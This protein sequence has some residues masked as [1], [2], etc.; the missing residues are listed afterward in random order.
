MDSPTFVSGGEPA[1]H[2]NQFSNLG[3]YFGRSGWWEEGAQALSSFFDHDLPR[4]DRFDQR[5]DDLL[6]RLEPLKVVEEPQV[7]KKDGTRIGPSNSTATNALQHEQ[8]L[9]PEEYN[10]QGD[11]P[12]TD[13]EPRV[14]G[15]RKD[16]ASGDQ[17]EAA[18]DLKSRREGSE[19][20]QFETRI[21]AQIDQSSGDKVS[22]TVASGNTL[23]TSPDPFVITQ[24]RE[25][26]A[27]VFNAVP[28]SLS[29]S[30]QDRD[31]EN[32]AVLAGTSGDREVT[33]PSSPL[34]GTT[35][36]STRQTS[37]NPSTR[38]TSVVLDRAS[39]FGPSSQKQPVVQIVL[40]ETSD[41]GSLINHT[42]GHRATSPVIVDDS[43]ESEIDSTA[44]ISIV[45]DIPSNDLDDN[46]KDSAINSEAD[47]TGI[48]AIKD[49]LSDQH[50]LASIHDIPSHQP[51][52]EPGESSTSLETD[53]TGLQAIKDELSDQYGLI[54]NPDSS[55]ISLEDDVTVLH[56]PSSAAASFFP[57]N[58][59]SP[60]LNDHSLEAIETKDRLIYE[61][62]MDVADEPLQITLDVHNF[63]AEPT[64]LDS[65][66]N[67]QQL[68]SR[69]FLTEAQII[70]IL[71]DTP[72]PPL[73]SP[74]TPP[75]GFSNGSRVDQDTIGGA[76]PEEHES[77]RTI[78]VPSILELPLIELAAITHK[79]KHGGKSG[80]T[81]LKAV[82]GTYTELSEELTQ[83]PEN[84][85]PAITTA[86]DKGKRRQEESHEDEP[87][88][89][90]RLSLI[91]EA[92]DPTSE[93]AHD[94]GANTGKDESKIP[95]QKGRSKV[96]TRPTNRDSPD[97]LASASPDELAHPPTSNPFA[98][99]KGP[100]LLAKPKVNRSTPRRSHAKKPAKDP[101]ANSTT[102]AAPS[103][104]REGR[105]HKELAGLLE[106]SPPRKAAE[107]AK[108]DV[109]GRLRSHQTDTPGPASI[110]TST[111]APRAELTALPAYAPQP[112][113]ITQ[114]AGVPE[115]Q[116]TPTTTTEA[117]PPKRQ[118]L[119]G[120]NPLGAQ[121]LS[122]LGTIIE[123]RTRTRNATAE[124][125][126]EPITKAT[127]KRVRKPAQKPAAVNSP[128][129]LTPK[130]KGTPAA[131][132]KKAPAKR[133]APE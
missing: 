36:A 21:P 3:D 53:P 112:E 91:P 4:A 28:K 126:N 42:A 128:F 17:P 107:K 5:P 95:I 94:L 58:S 47:P 72:S 69:G 96:T 2:D 73:F 27:S 19:T 130:S 86:V 11:K 118:R 77:S 110:L 22:Q 132:R 71:A 114:T 51:S 106:S 6:E 117:P 14:H 125:A 50:G 90:R 55:I 62:P 75:L 76:E 109:G 121:E 97:E 108:A 103:N 111:P 33:I 84:N 1:S 31:I 113:S 83:H 40:S 98:L 78:T 10:E 122:N 119:A 18:I 88:K 29:L 123:T 13:L 89:K 131:G 115:E 127:P 61:S 52:D 80:G 46:S 30:T 9:R 15:A 43:H 8:N 63:S 129:N 60:L 32:R 39:S 38:G 104:T 116:T 59:Y 102:A 54:T 34:F 85:V 25:N 70:K 124:L 100:L 101:A 7:S 45:Q 20:L 23:L 74:L 133:K 81:D 24:P 99:Q 26:L 120:A 35:A 57:P 65:A 56:D 12:R 41:R 64:A 37:H 87:T 66:P 79:K 92:E 67:H 105:G 49:E 82:R 16:Q 68:V 44:P 93:S 48:Q